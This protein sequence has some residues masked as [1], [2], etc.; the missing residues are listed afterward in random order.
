V[1]GYGGTGRP[2]EDLVRGIGKLLPRRARKALEEPARA[3]AALRPPPDL[4]AWRAAAAATADRAGLVLC[5]DLPT[6]LTLLV[7]DERAG[8]PADLVAAVRERPDALALVA[9]AASEEHL[10]LRQRLRVAI[11]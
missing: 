1:P 10:V 6:A 4:A 7:R 11:A 5:G 2:P 9:F 3:V 8:A